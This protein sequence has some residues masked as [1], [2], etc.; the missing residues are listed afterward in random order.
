[1]TN[2]ATK[3]IYSEQCSLNFNPGNPGNP[4]NPFALQIS[5]QLV[6]RGAGGRGEALRYIWKEFYYMDPHIRQV[7]GPEGDHPR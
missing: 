3:K 2:P 5:S 7:G 4:A 6:T 1:M